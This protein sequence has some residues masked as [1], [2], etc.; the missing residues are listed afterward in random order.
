MSFRYSKKLSVI[1]ALFVVLL[2]ASSAMAL[3]APSIALGE[4]GHAK[5]AIMITAGISGLPNGFTVWWMDQDTYNSY[6]GQWP[7]E[8]VPGLGYASF[9]GAPTLNTFGGLYTTFLLGTNE[10]VVVEIGDLVDETGVQGTLTELE[11][12]RTY[13]YVAFANGPGGEP[14]SAFS[15][16]LNGDTTPNDNCTFTWGYWKN[17]KEVWPVSDLTLGTVLYTMDELCAILD[18]PVQMNGLV[19][20]AHQLIAAKLNVANGADPSDVQAFIDAADALIDGLVIPPVGGGYLHPS[21]TSTLTQYLDD[22]N[23]GVIGPGHCGSV[24]TE[25]STWGNVKALFR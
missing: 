20:L 10:T 14:A 5:Q 15:P 17:H 2:L 16:T 3:D 18:Q 13:Y 21:A 4:A 22:F 7:A 11:Y 19:S 12:D 25:Q 24:P 23:N 6:G 1:V 9:T 8:V